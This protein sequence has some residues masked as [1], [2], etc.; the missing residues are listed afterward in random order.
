LDELPSL[1]IREMLL[2]RKL[3]GKRYQEH[4]QNLVPALIFYFLYGSKEDRVNSDPDMHKLTLFLS[5]AF[6]KGRKE[7]KC[8]DRCCRSGRWSRQPTGQTLSPRALQR[9]DGSG[10]Q[11]QQSVKASVSGAG[12]RAAEKRRSETDRRVHRN[13]LFHISFN[14]VFPSWLGKNI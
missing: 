5:G 9:Q 10:A 13:L 14:T 7:K 11:R 2:L 8:S 3:K 6:G 12:S 1:W 4:V